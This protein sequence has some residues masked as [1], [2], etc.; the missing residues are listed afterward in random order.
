MTEGDRK[1]PTL[2]YRQPGVGHRRKQ[3]PP[4]WQIWIASVLIALPVIDANSGGDPYWATP[5]ERMQTFVLVAIAVGAGL[6]IV[7]R[8]PRNVVGWLGLVGWGGLCVLALAGA[9][10][11]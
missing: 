4:S 7:R 1:T 9:L 10:L 6:F 2:D 3:T 8:R 11:K 5:A